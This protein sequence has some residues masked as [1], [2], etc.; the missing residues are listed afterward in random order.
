[1]TTSTRS[2]WAFAGAGGVGKTTTAEGVL[3][4]L[5]L[6]GH[7][8]FKLMP[9][10]SR[11]VFR[12]FGLKSEIDQR[13]LTPGERWALQKAIHVAHGEAIEAAAVEAQDSGV[14]FIAD[15]TRIDMLAYAVQYCTEALTGNDIEWLQQQTAEACRLYRRIFYFPLHTFSSHD[16]GMRET[17]YAKRYQ[18]NMLLQGALTHQVSK[19]TT[20]RTAVTRVTALD[21]G[22]RVIQV[23]TAI[24]AD[25]EIDAE[26]R[27]TI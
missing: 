21:L 17:S 11:A 15:R 24:N 12:A 10:P 25:M 7:E 27:G 6:Q 26:L 14:R 4:L 19:G 9:S 23:V 13:H 22:A 8:N 20:F 1:M 16:D 18:F 5:R 2:V 3:T